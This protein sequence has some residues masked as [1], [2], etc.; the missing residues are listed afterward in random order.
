MKSDY[1]QG[2]LSLLTPVSHFPLKICTINT[3]QTVPSAAPNELPVNICENM[4]TTTPFS[5]SA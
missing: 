4:S 1:F 3:I 5:F 2:V